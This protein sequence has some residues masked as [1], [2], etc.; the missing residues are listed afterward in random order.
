VGQ[1]TAAAQAADA[2]GLA[3][4]FASTAANPNYDSL[5]EITSA[6]VGVSRERVLALLGLRE[7]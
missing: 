6:L 3:Q 2:A 7:G 4:D 1:A 5:L